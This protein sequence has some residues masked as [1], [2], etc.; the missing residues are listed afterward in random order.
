MEED[1]KLKII[2]GATLLFLKFGFKSITMD[3]IVRELG[4]SKKTLYL[5]FSDK[6]ELVIKCIERHLQD[7]K[8]ACHHLRNKELNP[9]AFLIQITETLS[10]KKK[11]INQSILFDL[12]KY[13][14]EAW[15][16]LNEFRKEFIYHQMMDNLNSGKSEGYYKPDL[17][18][19]L[20]A[21]FY[22]HLIAFMVDPDN[23]QNSHLSI[24][25]IH[26]EMMKYHIRGIC[27]D[28]GI[29][30]FNKYLEKLDTQKI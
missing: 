23:D 15:E 14:K 3:D 11:Q 20:I 19:N 2:N 28:K 24:K 5:Y 12:K 4:I 21:K 8:N 10:D 29:K 25:D 9:V 1:L 22:I 27:T 18:E 30:I 17:N 7:E 26:F 6:N 16:L 13:F